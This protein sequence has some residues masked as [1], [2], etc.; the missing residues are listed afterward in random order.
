[1]L[2]TS[3]AAEVLLQARRQLELRGVHRRFL[4]R[5]E[6]EGRARSSRSTSTRSS[7]DAATEGPLERFAF[8]LRAQRGVA[9]LALLAAHRRRDPPA[10]LL[11]AAGHVAQA[12]HAAAARHLPH[13]LLRAVEA[14]EQ[15]VDVRGGHA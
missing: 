4:L 13:H 1:M 14:L 8:L 11:A 6:P 9:T 2:S 15:L 12:R 7:A 10:G 5:A 3:A